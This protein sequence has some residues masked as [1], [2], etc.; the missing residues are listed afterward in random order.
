ME[1]IQALERLGAGGEQLMALVQSGEGEV[2]LAAL[3]G[4]G[5][6]RPAD[7]I[8]LL[9]H[10]LASEDIAEAKAAMQALSRYGEQAPAEFLALVMRRFDEGRDDLRWAAINA[11]QKL[12]PLAHLAASRVVPLLAHKDFSETAFNTIEAMGP[13]AAEAALP[14]LE[15]LT[16]SLTHRGLA[17]RVIW[18]ISPQRAK[19]L[20]L[21]RVSKPGGT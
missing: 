12:G 7:A 9:M 8:P 17:R 3:R 11:F 1:A 14:E 18:A 16:Q 2:R 15:R 4:L 21:K 10:A 19:E 13:A 20:Q 5:G 6:A